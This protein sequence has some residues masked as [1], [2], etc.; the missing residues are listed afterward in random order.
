VENASTKAKVT[1]LRQKGVDL[2]YRDKQ[3]VAEKRKK[4]MESGKKKSTAFDREYRGAVPFGHWLITKAWPYKPD[5][6]EDIA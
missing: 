6:E 1:F 4:T 2:P 3:K 5:E